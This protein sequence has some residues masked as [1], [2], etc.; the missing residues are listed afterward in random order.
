M[1]NQFPPI[2]EQIRQSLHD[3]GFIIK[4]ENL[5]KPWGAYFLIDENQTKEFLQKY[6]PSISE[7]EFQPGLKLSPKILVVAPHMR[8]SW[9]Y[10]HRRQELWRVL[11]KPV[12]V[13]LND[14]DE[15]VEGK[16]YQKNDIIRIKLGE[17]H[18]LVGLDDWGL[19]AEI[20][21]HTDPSNPSNEDDIV[22]VQDDFSR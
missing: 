2:F 15:L 9:Q 6:F 11:G 21:I 4:E 13:V 19:V 18:R 5:A 7:N 1:M 3:G 10:H 22:R 8:L 17:R 12:E 20:W 14:T 16:T